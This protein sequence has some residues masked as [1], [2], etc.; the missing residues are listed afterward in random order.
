MPSGV[1]KNSLDGL[2]VRALNPAHEKKSVLMDQHFSDT[3]DLLRC[4]SRTEHDFGETATY[5]P[6]GVYPR[7]AKIDE[8]H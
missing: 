8:A 1:W 6:V 5:L 2:I 4:F 7:K 3:N